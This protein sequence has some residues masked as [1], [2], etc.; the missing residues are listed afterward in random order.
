MEYKF[1]LG[2]WNTEALNEDGSVPQN[3]TVEILNDTSIQISISKWKENKTRKISGQITGTVKYHRNFSG[4]GIKPRDIIVWLPPDYEK[5]KTKRYPV[6]YMHDGENIFDPATSSFGV[7]WRLDETADSLIKAN[8]IQEIIMVGIYNT[9]NRSAEYA[10]TDTG[11]LYMKF[12]VNELKPFIDSNYRTKPDRNNTATGGSSSGGLISFMLAWEYPNIFSKAACISPAF[13]IEDIDYLKTVK[14]YNGSKKQIKIYID[15]GGI[16][17]E[18]KLQPGIDSMLVLLKGKNYIE[19]KDLLFYKDIS[20]QHSEFYW[21]NR[22]WRF[23][24]FL[25]SN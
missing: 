24:K 18:N 10:D 17:L 13:Y 20:A 22:A 3:Y 16:G 11:K 2:S 25:F 9:S 4:E 7:D 12:V 6:L 14:N 15:D 23:L 21:G 8:E 5:E 19:G 1:T